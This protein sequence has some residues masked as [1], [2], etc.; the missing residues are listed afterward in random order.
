[1]RGCVAIADDIAAFR[2]VRR[3]NRHEVSG[4]QSCQWLNSDHAALQIESE[5]QPPNECH[6]NRTIGVRC[7]ASTDESGKVLAYNRAAPQ[8]RPRT[9]DR[10]CSLLAWLFSFLFGPTPKYAGERPPQYTAQHPC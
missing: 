8:R 5:Q 7:T 2:K 3:H 10:S 9:K 4:F 6:I 1:M